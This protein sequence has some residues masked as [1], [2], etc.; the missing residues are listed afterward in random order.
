MTARMFLT[1]RSGRTSPRDYL[2]PFLLDVSRLSLQGPAGRFPAGRD[3]GL[4]GPWLDRRRAGGASLFESAPPPHI[5]FINVSGACKGFRL[6]WRMN[7]DNV[8]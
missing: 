3:L 1:M 5:C 7:S 2:L 4:H 8:F 6:I